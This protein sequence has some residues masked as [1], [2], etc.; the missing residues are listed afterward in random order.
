MPSGGTGGT[1]GWGSSS[2]Q[3]SSHE[4][5]ACTSPAG[6]PLAAS[7]SDD[8]P[9]GAAGGECS[10][11]G[12]RMPDGAT[13]ARAGRHEGSSGRV[14]AA[15]DS[16]PLAS[17][18]SMDAA[19]ASHVAALQALSAGRASP[20]S[21]GGGA[22][23]DA[24]AAGEPLT[25]RGPGRPVASPDMTTAY[26]TQSILPQHAN[27]VG[28]TFGGQVSQAVRKQAGRHQAQRACMDGWLWCVPSTL[29]RSIC[30]RSLE[31][32]DAWPSV[33]AS[34]CGASCACAGIISL[35][36]HSSA[37]TTDCCVHVSLCMC[38]GAAMCRS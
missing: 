9:T 35:Q 13:I 15:A 27:T 33:P 8:Q 20:F 7:S 25:P 21:S 38:R 31:A 37:L 28:I 26:M 36:G 29:Q 3:R 19:S 23:A 2:G 4:H 32:R 17:A 24:A 12:A 6:Q 22:Q 5:A 14:H 16:Q 30:S 1:G 11:S 10:T 34:R 18:A